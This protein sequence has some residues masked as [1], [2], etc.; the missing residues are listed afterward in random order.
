MV[1]GMWHTTPEKT[2]LGCMHHESDSNHSP[3]FRFVLLHLKDGEDTRE[4][5]VEIH[6]GHEGLQKGLWRKWWKQQQARI[7][8]GLTFS[9]T[10]NQ[11]MFRKR[12]PKRLSKLNFHYGTS[13]L[14]WLFW[15]QNGPIQSCPHESPW[16]PP[17]L[18]YC[19]LILFPGGSSDIWTAL[20]HDMLLIFPTNSPDWRQMTP[21][22]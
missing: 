16:T 1:Y 8:A 21:D 14:F 4:S 12:V 15:C 11:S 18:H 7:I 17:A 20:W 10:V 3:E 6:R 22:L 2:S 5:L 13:T 19:L 9:S